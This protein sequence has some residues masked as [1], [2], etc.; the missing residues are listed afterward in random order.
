MSLALQSSTTDAAASTSRAAS[1]SARLRAWWRV[2][3]CAREVAGG[4]GKDG[5][6][7]E[8]CMVMVAT[9]DRLRRAFLPSDDLSSCERSESIEIQ[10]LARDTHPFRETHSGRWNTRNCGASSVVFGDTAPEFGRCL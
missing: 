8:V 10:R 5:S 1:N 2:W 3:G 7:D 4:A 6:A 9:T